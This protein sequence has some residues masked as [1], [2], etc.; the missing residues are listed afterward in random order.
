MQNTITVDDVLD[1]IDKW[2]PEDIIL[3]KKKLEEKARKGLKTLLA[4]IR[5]NN[6]QYSE[7]EVMADIQEEVKEIRAKRGGKN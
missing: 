3:L 6:E 4:E 1:S 7:E 5:K 2:K